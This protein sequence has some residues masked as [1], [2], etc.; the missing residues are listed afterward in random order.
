VRESDCGRV[1]DAGR[2]SIFGGNGLLRAFVIVVPRGRHCQGGGARA[3]ERPPA[4]AGPAARMGERRRWWLPAEALVELEGRGGVKQRIGGGI[5]LGAGAL[6]QRR[7]ACGCDPCP[8]MQAS[9]LMRLSRL[10]AAT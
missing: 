7:A 10:V 8:L 5:V 3:C 4:R 1:A 9:N 6:Q 2:A